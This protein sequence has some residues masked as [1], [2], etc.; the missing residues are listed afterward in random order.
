MKAG[1][2]K[3]A[4]LIDTGAAYKKMEEYVKVSNE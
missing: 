1:I 2:E 3:A 4:E